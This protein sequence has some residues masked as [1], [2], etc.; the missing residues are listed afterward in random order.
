MPKATYRSQQFLS[1]PAVYRAATKTDTIL[2]AII[3]VALAKISGVYAAATPIP[4]MELASHSAR[5]G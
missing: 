1:H 4:Y 3:V 2:S 5:S